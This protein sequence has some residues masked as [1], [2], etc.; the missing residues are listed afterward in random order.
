[1]NISPL[2][3]RNGV[4][5]TRLRL[6]SN[7]G[8][9]TVADY[10]LH[11]FGHLDPAEITQRL[12]N[13]EI[14][15]T[16]GT[17]LNLHTRMDEYQFCW[18]YRSVPH[19]DPLPVQYRILHRDDDLVVIDKPHFLPTTPGGRFI[20]ETALVRLRN[21][22]TLPELVPI[23]RLDRATA[24]VLLFSAN[25]A[26]RGAYQQL[27]ERQEVSKGYQ[28]V[29][30]L[31]AGFKWSG[32]VVVRNHITKEKGV[33]RSVVKDRLADP[34]PPNAVSRIELLRANDTHGLF[35]LT[36]YTGKTHQLR[37]HMAAIG[38]GIIND[39]FYPILLDKAPDNFSAPLQLLAQWIGFTDP[40][41]GTPRS[42]TSSLQLLHDPANTQP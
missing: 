32:P 21:E 8:F 19:E 22:L 34:V 31:P 29:A 10:L 28:A 36:P 27:F 3:V 42:F 23:H 30:A 11:R 5:A 26:T 35:Q 14:V 24:G 18:Y 4:N 2:P 1:M 12:E 15:A 7:S 25:P 13:G 6:P 20:Q 40:L 17:P 38:L 37:I 9:D 39:P 33:L 16:D 41:S